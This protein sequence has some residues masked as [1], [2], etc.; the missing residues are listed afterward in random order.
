[1]VTAARLR[2]PLA[3]IQLFLL[4]DLLSDSQ[5]RSIFAGG[6]LRA[7]GKTPYRRY[8]RMVYLSIGKSHSR[9][10]EM[11]RG[12]SSPSSLSPLSIPPPTSPTQEGGR[13]RGGRP[14]LALSLSPFSIP[15]PTS[16]S[17]GRWCSS[18]QRCPAAAHLVAGSRRRCA[19]GSRRLP[20]S[21]AVRS[22][23]RARSDDRSR[24]WSADPRPRELCHPQRPRPTSTSGSGFS[25]TP[26]LCPAA[27]DPSPS[28]SLWTLSLSQIWLEGSGR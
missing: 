3:K 27:A 11:G 6:R 9:R 16:P 28:P 2:G 25:S 20:C 26:S 12:L 1:M 15:P 7:L 24:R 5:R 13:C 23:A 4:A 8:K 18:M 17:S 21:A 22:E 10:R 14:L 19:G